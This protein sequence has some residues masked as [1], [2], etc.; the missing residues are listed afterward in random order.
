MTS[1]ATFHY[2]KTLLPV[3]YSDS[4]EYEQTD[5]KTTNPNAYSF[6]YGIQ[7]LSKCI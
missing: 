2:H 4:H 1:M 3:R 6:N 7:C 5:S